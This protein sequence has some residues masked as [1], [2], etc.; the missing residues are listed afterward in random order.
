[1]NKTLQKLLVL[2][3]LI[4]LFG[5]IIIGIHLRLPLSFYPSFL[6]IGLGMACL[7]SFIVHKIFFGPIQQMQRITEK[8]TRG[9]YKTRLSLGRKDELGQLA[10]NLNEM[11]LEL[12]NKIDE[13][14]H[15]KNE[16]KAILSSMV[17]GVVVIGKD[18]K[19]IL[20]SDP[21][22]QMLELRSKDVIGKP[23]WEIIRHEEINSLL[24][25]SIAQKKALQKEITLLSPNENHFSMQI[26]PVLS[27]DSKDFSGVV[28]IFHDIT[29]LKKLE[30]VRTE[31]V[32]NVSHELKTP[33][34]TIKGFVET[35]KEGALTDKEKSQRFLDIIQKH[36]DRLEYL[37][38]DL[39]T[40]SA[41]ESKEI[42]LN[43]E[44]TQIDKVIESAVHLCSEA[45]KQ[46]Q[47]Q[48]E[49]T[50]DKNLPD[51][52]L[53][54]A[55]M[56]QAFLNLLDN[57]IKFTNAG[58]NIRVSASHD[59]NFIRVDFKDNGIGIPQQHLPRLFERFY[60]VD[61]GRSRELGGTGLGLSIVKHIV[62]IHNGKVSV[63]SEPSKGSLFSVFL[64]ISS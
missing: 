57:A 40:I 25:E 7:L 37:V 30:D 54:K 3:I 52:L 47:H 24:E 45:L 17:E 50:V 64:P 27:E 61:K 56:E 32:A 19:I 60:R 21:V 42:K 6:V 62:Q 63:Q 49:I 55:K 41:I 43:F 15:D 2:N 46:K 9:D 26:S 11:S 10:N 1:M 16:L 8:I 34:T 48:L 14:T 35:L 36:T 44:Q 28:A 23:Y 12:Q 5:F 58:G 31:F 22:C 51:L 20:L 53:D 38:N 29:E 18:E 39:L 59:N 4:I 33:L 13:I